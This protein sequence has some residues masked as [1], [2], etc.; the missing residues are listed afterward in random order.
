MA[1][2]AA[3]GFWGVCTYSSRGAVREVAMVVP[4]R[5]PSKKKAR[6]TFTSEQKKAHRTSQVV[7]WAGVV[8]LRLPF[9]RCLWLFPAVL[10]GVHG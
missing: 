9:Q 5:K 1:S 7:Q 3:V 10:S 6:S 2:G 8:V 4:L